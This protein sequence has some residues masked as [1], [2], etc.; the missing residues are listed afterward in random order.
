[1]Q[2]FTLNGLIKNVTITESASKRFG[3]LT[4]LTQTFESTMQTTCIDQLG[5]VVLWR[6]HSTLGY[7]SWAALTAFNRHPIASD[8]RTL[9]KP[10]QSLVL[11]GL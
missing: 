4:C 8:F 5:Y 9:V 2:N 7:S 10:T 6:Y 3:R 1:M 11:P